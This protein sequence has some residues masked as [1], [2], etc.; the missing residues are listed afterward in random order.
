MILTYIALSVH[1]KYK[2]ML[3]WTEMAED[4]EKDIGETTD[5]VR[6]SG[7]CVDGNNVHRK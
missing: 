2:K 5:L 1:G 3:Y 7:K 6:E 4:F